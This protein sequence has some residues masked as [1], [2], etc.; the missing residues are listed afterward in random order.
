MSVIY[1]Q[2]MLY[3]LNC[4]IDVGEFA[5]VLRVQVK[6]ATGNEDCVVF[7]QLQYLRI[8]L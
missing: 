3:G 5:K 8:Y 6:L 2:G 1:S 4:K 7:A